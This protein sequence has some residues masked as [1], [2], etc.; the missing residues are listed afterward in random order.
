MQRRKGYG[1]ISAYGGTAYDFTN[2]A[3][4]DKPVLAEHGEKTI[5]IMYAVKDIDVTQAASGKLLPENAPTLTTLIGKM[6]TES[7]E[8]STSSCRGACAGLCAGSCIGG[9]NGCSG[10]CNAG[11]QGCTASCGSSCA[12]GLMYA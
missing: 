4:V 7:M 5:N 1:D 11:C 2:A 10:G 8:G 12:S 6:S 3:S 9:C